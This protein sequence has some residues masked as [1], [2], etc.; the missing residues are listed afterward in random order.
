MEA[1]LKAL[2]T[3]RNESRRNKVFT[4]IKHL[5]MREYSEDTYLSLSYSIHMIF[6][7]MF[8]LSLTSCIPNVV[9]R[10]LT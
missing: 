1:I 7:S 5:I 4:V 10:E 2:S 8:S 9:D 6:T 3:V